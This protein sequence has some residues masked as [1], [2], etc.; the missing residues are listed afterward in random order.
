MVNKTHLLLLWLGFAFASLP[1][2]FCK[3]KSILLTDVNSN[4]DKSLFSFSRSLPR[5]SWVYASYYVLCYFKKRHVTD[6]NFT[7]VTKRPYVIMY[8]A[9]TVFEP[10]SQTLSKTVK[11]Q[12]KSWAD[13][14]RWNDF[15]LVKSAFCLSFWA[16]HSLQISLSRFWHY[17]T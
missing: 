14:S 2:A 5:S 12:K 4:L 9:K 3:S 11:W 13:F 10:A 1:W 6:L 8:A 16:L 7:Y 17:W 15:R